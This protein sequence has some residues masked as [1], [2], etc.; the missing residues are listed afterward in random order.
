MKVFAGV[1][2]GLAVSIAIPAFL[3]IE[4]V[5]PSIPLGIYVRSFESIRVG[6]IVAFPV[7]ACLRAYTSHWP[8]VDAWAARNNLMKPVVGVAGD[9][10]CR[11]A[12]TNIFS[13][14]GR[15]LGMAAAAGHDGVPLPSWTGCT[16]LSADQIAVFAD[17]PL[18]L[19][20]RFFGALPRST[21]T[22]YRLVAEKSQLLGWLR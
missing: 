8:A 22:A 7:P 14:N 9:T 4:N 18:C 16:T 15:A 12:A 1:L 13:V 2:L 6:S 3:F 21:V 20:S 5:T 10:I 17:C 19:D 11:D